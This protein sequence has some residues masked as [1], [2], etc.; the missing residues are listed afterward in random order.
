MGCL[1]R[2]DSE[3]GEITEQQK[4]DYIVRMPI[5][6]ERSLIGFNVSSLAPVF[7]T[8]VATSKA[9]GVARSVR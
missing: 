4:W 6:I 5:G 3:K 8:V 1:G 2:S 7:R 9:L